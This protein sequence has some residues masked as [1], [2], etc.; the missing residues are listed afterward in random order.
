LDYLFENIPGHDLIPG[1]DLTRDTI[2]TGIL[3]VNPEAGATQPNIPTYTAQ[4]AVN[5]TYYQVASALHASLG[6]PDI[7]A[8]YFSEGRLIPPGQI[9]PAQLS[10]YSNALQNYLFHHGYPNLGTDFKS[11]YDDGAGK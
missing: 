11:F 7:P 8:E 5:S 6:N 1:I 4:H 3:G 9:P 10:D 2:A